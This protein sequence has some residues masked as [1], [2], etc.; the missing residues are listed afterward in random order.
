MALAPVS[1]DAPPVSDVH[2]AG[3]PASIVAMQG[4]AKVYPG[5]GGLEVLLCFEIL[6]AADAQDLNTLIGGDVADCLP[7]LCQSVAPVSLAAEVNYITGQRELAALLSQFPLDRL[8][9]RMISSLSFIR[10]LLAKIRYLRLASEAEGCGTLSS[11]TLVGRENLDIMRREWTAMCRHWGQRV[12]ALKQD[13]IDSEDFL[14]QGHRDAKFHHQARIRELT[15]QVARLQDQLRDSETAR[16][17]AERRAAEHIL[18]VIALVDF[19]MGNQPKINMMF[20]WIRLA[21]LLHHF[22]EGTPI[23]E[24]WLTNYNVVGLDDP[25]CECPEYARP[26]PWTSNE[27]FNVRV[28]DRQPETEGVCCARCAFGQASNLES[29]SGPETNV[30]DARDLA[31]AGRA[32]PAG[33]LWI[34][35]REDVQ[36]LLLSGMDFKFTMEWVSESQAG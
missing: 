30:R 3:V 36:Y 27:G 2:L 32:L 21:A 8:A 28:A 34:D 19:L 6:D 13:R 22:A 11:E 23:P 10:R 4:G 14:R 31:E 20:N 18:D 12:R 33:M 1:W 5:H 16:Q 25:R 35:V 17:A 7:T 24:G 26:S 29:G 15:D 9:E